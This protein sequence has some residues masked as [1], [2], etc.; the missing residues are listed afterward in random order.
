MGTL[1]A[2]RLLSTRPRTEMIVR[3]PG[4]LQAHDTRVDLSK[5][6][7][8]PIKTVSMTESQR[9]EDQT[10][11]LGVSSSNNRSGDESPGPRTRAYRTHST[12]TS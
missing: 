9:A 1:R 12:D 11:T 3:A 2:Q 6:G 10:L 5:E 7:R 4:P 8:I